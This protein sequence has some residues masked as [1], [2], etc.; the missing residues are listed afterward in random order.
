MPVYSPID[1]RLDEV[2]AGEPFDVAILA[3]WYVAEML[4]NRI[5]T[6]S[7]ETRV[8]VDSMDLH[9]VRHARRAFSLRGRA[10]S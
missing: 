1:E 9:F 4:I 10:M 5:R 6:S 3:F 7:P 2:I 8:I